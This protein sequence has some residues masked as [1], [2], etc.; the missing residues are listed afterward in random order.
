MKKL[1]ILMS[2]VML[3]AFTAG[4]SL[5]AKKAAKLEMLTGEV[6]KVDV[7]KGNLV[8]KI[9]GKDQ[10]LKAEPQMLAGITVGE[11]VTIEKSGKTL[12]SIKPAEAPAEK[13]APKTE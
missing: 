10:T 1:A 3:V 13:E 2:V 7:K 4:V 5:A 11:K 8:I 6:V 9:N 12:K